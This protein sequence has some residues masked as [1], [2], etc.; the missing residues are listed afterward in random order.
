MTFFWPLAANGTGISGGI[1][2]DC[3]VV[4]SVRLAALDGKTACC[5]AASAAC[6]CRHAE[7]YCMTVFAKAMNVTVS[8]KTC[9]WPCR[10]RPRQGRLA[11]RKRP[12]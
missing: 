6:A 3:M 12:V 2:C 4:K 7:T 5:P 10:V 1:G 8:G 11:G 9:N